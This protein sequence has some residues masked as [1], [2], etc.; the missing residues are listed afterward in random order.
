VSQ[1]HLSALAMSIMEK[2]VIENIINFGDKV[3]DKFAFCKERRMDF[4]TIK[5]VNEVISY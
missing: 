1:Y 2:V 4:C 5:M 3:I